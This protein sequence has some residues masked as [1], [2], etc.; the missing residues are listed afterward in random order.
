MSEQVMAH[1][2][3]RVAQGAKYE[4]IVEECL[5]LWIG[6]NEIQVREYIDKMMRR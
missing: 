3:S 5:M 1:I 4:T 2:R 6:C